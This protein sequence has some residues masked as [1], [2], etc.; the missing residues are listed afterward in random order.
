MWARLRIGGEMDIDD[1]IPIPNAIE[2][3]KVVRGMR[4]ES[5]RRVICVTKWE[6]TASKTHDFQRLGEASWAESRD[7]L[8]GD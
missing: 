7:Y 6:N 1:D 8:P 5:R 4:C 3:H 2:K